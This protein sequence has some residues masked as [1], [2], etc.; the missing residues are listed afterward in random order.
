MTSF[1][2]L[3]RI[4][5]SVKS[6]PTKYLLLVIAAL[7]GLFLEAYMHNFNIVYIALFFIFAC[8]Q[9]ACLVGRMNLGGLEA[10]NLSCGRL[11]A[12]KPGDCRIELANGSRQAAYALQ[13]LT[14]RGA[15]A[16]PN[17]PAY[18][19]GHVAVHP[20]FETRG[21][22]D[23]PEV[24]VQSLF[25]LATVRFL[26]R[27]SFSQTVLVYPEPA[28]VSLE[29]KFG[30]ELAKFGEPED[31][32]GLRAYREG[33]PMSLIHWPSFAKGAMLSKAFEMSDPNKELILSYRDAGDDMETR[34]SQLTL[35]VLACEKKGIA[36]TLK[37]PA[38]ALASKKMSVD[39]IL[40]TL[41]FF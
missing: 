23:F 2:T 20:V 17:L 8:A 7:V 34:L 6:R 3:I 24:T 18:G 41:A 5:K 12:R 21:Y 37:L 30:R 10:G 16:L 14:D 27:F 29:Q 31:F 22:H 28:G 38:M 15:V 36:F 39:A 1:R 35:W 26:R 33:E 13:V 11:F 19:R 25:P 9:S 40:E 4:Y 32:E